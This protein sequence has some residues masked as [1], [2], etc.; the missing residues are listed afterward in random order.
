MLVYAWAF[1]PRM[2]DRDF[3]FSWHLVCTHADASGPVDSAL[4]QRSAAVKQAC[5]AVERW[6][7]TRELCACRR[8]A[9]LSAL[10]AVATAFATTAAAHRGAD[11]RFIIPTAGAPLRCRAAPM[12]KVVHLRCVHVLRCLTDTLTHAPELH[13]WAYSTTPGSIGGK[14]SCCRFCSSIAAWDGRITHI[15]KAASSRQQQLRQ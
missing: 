2:Y 6:P 3:I 1:T 11:R 5:G 14:E 10:R 4:R 7:V 8:R 12:P 9:A 13:T 15:F